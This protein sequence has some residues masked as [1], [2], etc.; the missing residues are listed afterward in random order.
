MSDLQIA[1][2]SPAKM[3]LTQVSQFVGSLLLVFVLLILGWMISTFI[4]KIAVTK[5][6]KLLKVDELSHR[7]E[8]DLVLAKGGINSTL[9]DLIG[10]IFYWL[11]LLIT[12][13]V[14]LN[15]VGLTVAA[16][17]L[18]KVVLF[19]PNII[20]AIFILIIGMFAA[21]ILR[22]IVRTAANN[23]GI[24]QANFVSNIA[25]VVVIVFAVATALEQ[26]Q[27]GARIVEL[28]IGIVLGS[29][30]LGFA[31]AFGLGCKDIVGKTVNDFLNKLTK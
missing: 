24:S 28:T 30:G 11:S 17:L 8:L 5:I 19:I 27:I 15:A 6:L 10:G 2:L 22:N 12:F 31:I 3:I 20:A 7:I 4:I 21:V 18:Q 9:S 29:L 16:E 23:A 13:V 25:E 26:L 14:T 1:L